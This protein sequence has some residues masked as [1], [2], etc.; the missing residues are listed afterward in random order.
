MSL[1]AFESAGGSSRQ[2]D[3]RRFYPAAQASSWQSFLGVS[4]TISAS[5][6]AAFFLHSS[7]SILFLVFLNSTQPFLISQLGETKKQGSLSG[8]LVFSDELLSMFLVLFWGSLADIIGTKIVAV[9]GYCFIAIALLSYT[10]AQVPWPDLLF[11]RL[12]FAIGG[13]AVTAM[14]SGEFEKEQRKI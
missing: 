1:P 5:N 13:S 9:I 4:P 8:T 12:T 6:I 3:G 10:F 14:L 2:R 7:S 11:C